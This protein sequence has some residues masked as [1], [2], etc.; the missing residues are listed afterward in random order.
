MGTP[1]VSIGDY[2]A[3]F[4]EPV[5]AILAEMRR[6]VCAVAPEAVETISYGIPTLKL[7]GKN[8]VHFA[9]FTHHIGFYPTASGIAAFA[10][11]LSPYS[12]SRGTVRFPLDRPI[13]YDL[14]R[15]IVAFRVAEISAKT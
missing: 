8:L 15:R 9:A 1:F 2:I 3:S 13:P 4:P 12:T 5:Q 11:E 6:Q 14:V 7:K 10:A